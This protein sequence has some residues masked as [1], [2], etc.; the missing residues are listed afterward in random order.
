MLASA[1]AILVFF[2][3]TEGLNRAS[4]TK[5]AIY[6]LP[7][8]EASFVFMQGSWQRVDSLEQSL[9]STC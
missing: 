3:F 2:F 5:P 7:F 8:A 9:A 6:N 1:A 4:H